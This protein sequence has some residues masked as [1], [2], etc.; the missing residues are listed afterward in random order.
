MPV[1]GALGR[2]S[3]GLATHTVVRDEQRRIGYVDRAFATVIEPAFKDA[4]E[5]TEGLAA[6]QTHEGW[7]FIDKKGEWVIP[8]RY[9]SAS[10]FLGGFA[11]VMEDSSGAFLID[12]KGQRRPALPKGWACGEGFSEGRTVLHPVGLGYGLLMIDT[13]GKQV[14]AFS[15]DPPVMAGE[16]RLIMKAGNEYGLADEKGKLVT[17]VAYDKAEPFHEGAA[18]VMDG[19]GAFFISPEGKPL[20]G[21]R[22]VTTP[23]YSEGLAPVARG[24]WVEYAQRL[25][26]VDSQGRE[27]SSRAM[28]TQ[29]F[30]DCKYAFID[31]QGKETTPYHFTFAEPFMQGLAAVSF[32]SCTLDRVPEHPGFQWVNCPKRYGY[33]GTDGRLVI[34]PAFESFAPDAFKD[35]VAREGHRLFDREG[36]QVWGD[37]DW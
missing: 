9:S 4:R 34:A 37:P 12:A 19:R 18:V 29:R 35:G 14:M 27:Q 22:Y 26:I 31:K 7:G 10:S 28:P 13:T 15:A 1:E 3:E 16:R 5:F 36:N 33:V 23:G 24:K 8:A 11:C 25:S 17:P 21:K 20:T 2:F 32:G 6:V 30:C